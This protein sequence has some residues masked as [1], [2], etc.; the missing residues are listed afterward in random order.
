M[1]L[2]NHIAE[3]SKTYNIVGQINLNELE[4]MPSYQHARWINRKFTELYQP[5]YQNNQRIIVTLDYKC[6]KL[7]INDILQ[8]LQRQINAIDIS[9]FFIVIVAPDFP[10]IK[11]KLN[12]VTNN[13]SY[14]PVPMQLITFAVDHEKVV[15]D[16]NSNAPLKIQLNSL[17]DDEKHL[18]TESKT[19]C[20]YPW[21]HIHAYPTGQAY[22]CCMSEMSHPI[23]NT[24]KKHVGRIMEWT[25]IASNTSGHAQ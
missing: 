1:S 2:N 23:G 13:I 14:D 6:W 18:L 10:E 15:Y 17:L 24:K 25:R 8:E 4:S 21:V 9:N 20:M 11:D 16:Y 7:H 3:L 19:F 22:P 12:W 5:A